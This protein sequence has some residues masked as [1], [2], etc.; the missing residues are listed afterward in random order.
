MNNY[1]ISKYIM[2]QG[3]YVLEKTG[4][5]QGIQNELIKFRENENIPKKPGKP[6]EF[7]FFRI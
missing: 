5:N 6:M 7:F 2:I 3:S 4:N 1:L